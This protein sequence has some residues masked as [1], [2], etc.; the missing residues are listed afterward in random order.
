MGRKICPECNTIFDDKVLIEKKSENCL[1]CGALLRDMDESESTPDEE[2][3][4]WY[5]YLVGKKE[6]K[7]KNHILTKDLMKD[8]EMFTL[9]Y[10]FTAPDDSDKA[11]EILRKEY[12]SNALTPYVNTNSEPIVRCPR[13]GSTN[14]QLVQRKWSIWVGYRS[15]A[16]QRVC[17]NCKHRF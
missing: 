17:V 9:E 5:Y 12:D 2:L 16:V 8:N 13:C 4:D 1:V 15:N 10:Q 3:V 11:K 6:H 7:V 14:I